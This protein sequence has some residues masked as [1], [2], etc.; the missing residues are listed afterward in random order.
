MQQ[1]RA[2]FCVLK[3]SVA[4]NSFLPNSSIM[5]KVPSPLELYMIFRRLSKAAASGPS[6][7]GKVLVTLPLSASTTAITLLSQTL[8]KLRVLVSIASP[9]GLSQ[10]GRGQLF[11]TLRVEASITQIMFLSSRLS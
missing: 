4:E 2:L 7:M 1:V 10:L 3:V 6:P 11:K 8:N 5:L 9:L